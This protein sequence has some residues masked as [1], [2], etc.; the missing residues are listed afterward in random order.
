M[1][2]ATPWTTA[3]TLVGP[4]SRNIWIRSITNS[5]SP[6]SEN[7]N[8]SSTVAAT[9]DKEQYTFGVDYNLSKRTAVYTTYAEISNDGAS[10]FS[11]LPGAP[12]TSR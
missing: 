11:V 3:W 8:S 4:S 7:D 12:A 2:A 10:S 5:G 9:A 6:S 1:P